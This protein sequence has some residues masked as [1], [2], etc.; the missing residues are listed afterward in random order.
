MKFDTQGGKAR[1]VSVQLCKAGITA[2]D[3][4]DLMDVMIASEAF[5]YEPTAKLGASVI[6]RTVTELF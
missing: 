3:A 6:D 1:N 5:V 4:H 2:R